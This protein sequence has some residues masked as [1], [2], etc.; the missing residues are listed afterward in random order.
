MTDSWTFPEDDNIDKDIYLAAGS[1][2]GKIEIVGDTDINPDTGSV[3]IKSR[4]TND[5]F[6]GYGFA[7]GYQCI[8]CSASNVFS[9]VNEDCIECLSCHKRWTYQEF[10]ND[11]DFAIKEGEM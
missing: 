8:F 11:L 10:L 3:R 7:L 9:D 6:G 4:H 5:R 1:D 2:R